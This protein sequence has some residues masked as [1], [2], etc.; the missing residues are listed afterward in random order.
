LKPEGQ[1]NSTGRCLK[2]LMI[3][4]GKIIEILPARF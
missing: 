1:K 4:A 3:F 2:L